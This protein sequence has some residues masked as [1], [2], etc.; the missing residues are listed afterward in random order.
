MKIALIQMKVQDQK[1]LN[2]KKAKKHIKEAARNGA[3]LVI[4]PEMFNT[5]Y[6]NSYFEKFA[7]EYPGESTDVLKNLAKELNLVI[8]GGSIP[9]RECEHIYNTSYVF[10]KK[11]DLIAKHRKIHLFDIDVEGG[12][13]FKE[14]D[15]LTAGEDLTT[16][17]VGDMK[18]GLIVCYDI[19]FPDL[20]M[21]LALKGVDAIIV[22]AAFNMTTG[23]AHWHL[24][25][26]ARALDNQVYTL[27]C[28]QSR[29]EDSSYRAY[30]HSLVASP[31]GNIQD[32][33]Q[34]EEGI[35]YSNLDKDYI[36]KVRGELPLLKH[37]RPN[38]YEMK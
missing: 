37:R 31:W 25:A 11:G 15:T 19:R 3:E 27:L 1:S 9:E 17:Q 38:I 6:N 29:N 18:F 10:S 28:S 4:L 7:E 2:L 22:P 32:E 21:N 8:V 35:L 14:S 12:A 30:G 5:P 34:I 26:R 20:S 24:S 16:F 23:P 33:L 13:K 36:T